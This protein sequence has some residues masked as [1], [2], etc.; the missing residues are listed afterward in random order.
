MEKKEFAKYEIINGQNVNEWYIKKNHP[1]V[2]SLAV[3]ELCMLK[4]QPAALHLY[5]SNM[6]INIPMKQ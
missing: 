2:C 5:L 3:L 6:N 4:I 1:I